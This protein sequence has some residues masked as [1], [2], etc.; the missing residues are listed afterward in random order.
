MTLAAPSAADKA[1]PTAATAG[2]D[3]R[4]LGLAVPLLI[5]GAVYLD[6]A[7]AGRQAVLYLLGA[8]LGLVLY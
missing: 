1:A 6:Q 4:V 7:V 5:G 2:P 8:A 3:W